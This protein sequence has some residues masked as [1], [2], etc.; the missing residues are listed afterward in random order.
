MPIDVVKTR[1]QTFSGR[2]TAKSSGFFCAYKIFT[3]EG[4][5]PL[6]AGLV[7]RLVR[8]SVASVLIFQLYEN[9]FKLVSVADKIFG[10]GTKNAEA[11]AVEV[12]FRGVD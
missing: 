5:K 1:M 9:S 4:I 7:P 6:F 8:V 10:T 12:G 3:Q 2:Q 11:K